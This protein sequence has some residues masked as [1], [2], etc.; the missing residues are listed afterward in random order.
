MA[1]YPATET[2]IGFIDEEPDGSWFPEV[3]LAFIRSLLQPFEQAISATDDREALEDWMQQVFPSLYQEFRDHLT[4]DND[5]DFVPT[6]NDIRQMIISTIA[7]GLVSEDEPDPDVVR[8]PWDLVAT[9]PPEIVTAL[10]LD[11]NSRTLP[12]TVTVGPQQFTHQMTADQALGLIL[13][14]TI[15]GVNFHPSMYGTELTFFQ[16]VFEYARFAVSDQ[17]D[18][19]YRVE[20]DGRV[21]QFITPDFMQG[22]ATGALWTGTDHHAFWKHLTLILTPD[23]PPATLHF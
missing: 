21:Y 8:L 18:S 2:V 13:F 10:G 14:S 7:Y 17:P 20:I 15:A 1:A 4:L 12:V 22:F 5:G 9:A 23:A 19:K 6:G 16:N 3:T 11:P